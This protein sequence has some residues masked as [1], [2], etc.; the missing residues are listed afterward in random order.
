MFSYSL[1]TI[2]EYDKLYD[3][4]LLQ[5]NHDYDKLK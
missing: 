1:T 4:Y 3:D 5:Q 2:D